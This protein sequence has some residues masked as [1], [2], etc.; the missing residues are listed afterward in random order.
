MRQR[1]SEDHDSAVADVGIPICESI[2]AFAQGRY[3]DAAATLLRL[4]PVTF[5]LGGSHA[6][7]DI[8]DQYLIEAAIRGGESHLATALLRERKLL[9]PH[10]GT[11]L[12]EWVE[13]AGAATDWAAPRFA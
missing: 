9:K 1:A 2:L 12:A 7:R 4:R 6:Q 13:A 5:Q 11:T 10:S 8:L 3:K